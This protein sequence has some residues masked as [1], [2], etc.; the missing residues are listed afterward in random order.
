VLGEVGTGIGSSVLL[1][2]HY[3]IGPLVVSL[4]RAD[5]VPMDSPRLCSEAGDE[6][7]TEDREG[8]TVTTV[9]VRPDRGGWYRYLLF[10][11][12]EEFPILRDYWGPRRGWWRSGQSW[13]DVRGNWVWVGSD[14]EWGPGHWA[15]R[16]LDEAWG[17]P[18]GRWNSLSSTTSLSSAIADDV[19]GSPVSGASLDSSAELDRPRLT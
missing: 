3:R 18:Y 13:Y 1:S 11:S 14:E 19:L 10:R 6:E 15:P 2:C 7:E 12:R 16:V 17:G 4:R 9:P 5:R 8:A